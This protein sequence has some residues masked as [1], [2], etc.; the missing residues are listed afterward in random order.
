LAAQHLRSGL[1]RRRDQVG[2]DIARTDV[3][4]QRAGHLVGQIGGQRAQNGSG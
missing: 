2:G 4:A 1:R 3:L